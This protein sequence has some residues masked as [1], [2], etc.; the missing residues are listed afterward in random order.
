MR[1]R[2]HPS[3]SLFSGKRFQTCKKLKVDGGKGLAGLGLSLLLF[4]EAA[5]E[6]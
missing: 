6:R 1:S 2:L 5:E 4:L 3:G